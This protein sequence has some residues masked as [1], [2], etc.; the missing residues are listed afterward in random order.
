MNENI[1]VLKA[2]T[3]LLFPI[4]SPSTFL[5]LS[6]RTQTPVYVQFTT[7]LRPFNSPPLLYSITIISERPENK[8]TELLPY[9]CE[10]L[11]TK[12]NT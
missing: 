6:D 11:L 10:I 1:N 5:L 12:E 2:N 7:S 4:P 3:K 9:Q 8:K